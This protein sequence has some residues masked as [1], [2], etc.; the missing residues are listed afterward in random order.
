MKHKFN[1]GDVIASI[2]RELNDGE[3]LKVGYKY[4][5]IR[6]TNDYTNKHDIIWIDESFRL[7]ETPQEKLIKSYFG[8]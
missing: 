5:T 1:V 4:Y 6:Q 7:K 3:I 2:D 8:L